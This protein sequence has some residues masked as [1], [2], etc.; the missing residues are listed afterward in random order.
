M[1]P[2]WLRKLHQ[3]V[4]LLVGL[5]LLVWTCSG[6]VMSLL[7][8]KKV[9]GEEF[10]VTSTS[11]RPWPANALSVDSLLATATAPV[12]SISSGWLLDQP[13]YRL[14]GPQGP[15]LVDASSGAGIV[16]S[17][18][19][20]QKLALAT[21]TGPGHPGQAELLEP[22]LETRA[23]AGRVWRVA[24]SD[25]E[26]TSVYLSQQGELLWHR[27]RS[28]RLYDFFWM[29]HI[30][31]YSGR[32]DFNNY[33]LL[34][35]AVGGLGLALSGLGLLIGRLRQINWTGLGRAGHCELSLF[36]PAGEKLQTLKAV[37]GKIVYQTLSRQGLQ[38]PS[39][40]GG[41]QSCG[42]C[43]VR[44]LG[45]APAATAADREHL[46]ERKIGSGWR[47]ACNLTIKQGLAIELPE[48]VGQ[49]TACKARVEAVRALS[50]F[51]RE[52]TLRP[53][54]PAAAQF[55]PGAYLQ[56]HIPPYSMERH[57]I[58]FP[59]DQASDW[60]AL[61]LPA[62]WSNTQLLRRAYSL[63]C[64]VDQADGCLT[65]LVRIAHGRQALV[66]HPPGIGS[67]YL[68]RLK[69]GDALEFT[70]P[71]G[72]FAVQSGG[73]QKVFIG[74]GAGMAPLRA[75]IRSLLETGA[76]E[77]IQFWY[78]AQSLRDAPY[79]AE[80]KA[81]ALQYA[82][83][84]WHLV[85]SGPAAPPELASGISTGLVHERAQQAWLREGLDFLAC[86]FYICG[87][88]AMLAATRAMLKQ[89]GVADERVSFDDFKS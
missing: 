23:H 84:T 19:L 80:M 17:A 83:F 60:A 58:E 4:G 81:F 39:N 13:V 72:D 21:Y 14:A 76:A 68:Y 16:L 57:Q 31:D 38:L 56:L 66:N 30:M 43:M 15:R 54:L 85:L 69:P 32:T 42:L 27:N 33:L 12:Q 70:G 10:R 71:F 35:M 34:S 18:E 62:S 24:F 45:Q 55:R 37:P 77:R 20:V 82:N 51:L 61:E 44:V 25:R 40:C 1:M 2:R 67:S 50:P 86:D 5:Q 87:P 36:S 75:M 3:I 49:R 53:E 65:L 41:G 74:G 8:T 59:A 29:L 88:P 22:S 46:S 26:D 48:G 78:G 73:R 9:R 6:L 89:R 47:L 7:D 79:V 11:P 28:W 63:A 52:I 64:P